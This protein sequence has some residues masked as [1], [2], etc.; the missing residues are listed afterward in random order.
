M[1][2]LRVLD[3]FPILTPSPG[4]QPPLPRPIKIS[5]LRISRPHTVE[6][7][8]AHYFTTL[9]S[10]TSETTYYKNTRRG[11][12]RGYTAHFLKNIFLDSPK[13]RSYRVKWKWDGWID[14]EVSKRA[15]TWF[16]AGPELIIFSGLVSHSYTPLLTLHIDR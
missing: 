5:P 16:T 14:S 7:C 6:N 11:G 12:G 15:L 8:L 1:A 10:L 3:K 9:Q 4:E 13:S 2:A